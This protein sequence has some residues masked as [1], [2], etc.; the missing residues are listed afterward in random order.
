[1][2]KDCDLVDTESLSDLVE[3]WTEVVPID[4]LSKEVKNLALPARQRRHGHG[5]DQSRKVDTSN[6]AKKRYE[7][8]SL[9]R[10][11]FR[12]DILTDA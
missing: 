8:D 5:L 12:G 7:T 6:T 11:S 3:G 9:C 2:A 1:M 4:V 10:E